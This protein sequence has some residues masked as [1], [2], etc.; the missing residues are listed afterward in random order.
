MKNISVNIDGKEFPEFCNEMKINSCYSSQ[1][2]SYEAEKCIQ[3]Q[4]CLDACPSGALTVKNFYSNNLLDKAK[5]IEKTDQTTC[6]YC[7]V[8]CQ[9]DVSVVNGKIVKSVGA[10]DIPNF[11]TAC[12]KGRFGLDF[13]N[14]KGRITKPLIRKDGKLVE[15]EWMEAVTFAASKLRSLRKIHGS[16]ALAGLSSVKS[17]NEANYVFQKF[18]RSILHTNHVDHY[19]PLCHSSTVDGLVTGFGTGAMTN[20]IGELEN[21]DAILIT[22]S[23]TTE[24]HPVIAAYIIKA[25]SKG[26]KLIIIDPKENDLVR[27]STLWLKPN[28][29][30]DVA[31]I[32]G[33]MNVIINDNIQDSTFINER[34]EG[35][36]EFKETV[37][38]Y[39]TKLVEEITGIPESKLIEAARI[40]A[41]VG[42]ASIVFSMG[43][44]H[45]IGGVDNVKSLA[46]LAMITGNVGKESTG[47]NP[48]CS[49]NNIQ[50]VCDMG[51]LPNYYPGY[52]KVMEKKIEK[53]FVKAWKTELSHKSGLTSSGMIN[54]A[55]NGDLKAMYIMGEN[56]IA[57]EVNTHHVK[58]ALSNL[59]LLICQDS[60]FN[61]TTEYAD[62]VFPSASFSECEGTYTSTERR[63]LPIN[64][65][66]E[67][68][69]KSREDWEIIQH[70]ASAFGV[71]WDYNSWKDI[72]EEINTV[73]PQY[74][75]ITASRVQNGE[76]LQWP[77]PT[78]SHAGTK[79]LY[80][81]K[82][83][84]GKGLLSVID[85]ISSEL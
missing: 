70:M 10:F 68:L 66:Y 9:L 43:I 81:D 23:N 17:T 32:N 84:R 45:Q 1:K 50:G 13:I 57:S 79:Y 11:G 58:E 73:T 21:A 19:A 69:G 15:V 62:V 61:E 12:V 39:N 8:G 76:K 52:Q 64:K 60:F 85:Y 30:T 56:P 47:V 41:K 42:K 80:K 54:A 46:N 3:C 16:N 37:L 40:Y 51:V 83:V 67:P 27:Y 65:I 26:S 63:I 38:K 24:T 75:G 48:L 53:K 49:Q 22:G 72:M 34:T 20:S 36:D 74:A 55:V 31:W 4:K 18:M 35:F 82:F 29:G 33:M 28:Y 44:T 77:C 25:V 71:F 59:D 5:E 6:P 2:L 78:E 7:G 14:Q